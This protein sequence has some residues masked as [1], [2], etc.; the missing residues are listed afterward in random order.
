MLL[1][2]FSERVDKQLWTKNPDLGDINVF[3]NMNES[4]EA[5]RVTD[6]ILI[7]REKEYSLSDF[8][9]FYRTNAQSRALEDALRRQGLPYAIIG[10]LK[11]YDRAEI[12][13]IMAYLK[14]I[15]NPNDNISFKRVVNVPKR[16]VGKTSI[17][18]LE[19]FA[20]AKGASLFES[21]KFVNS[22]IITN[23]S[24]SALNSFKSI[25]EK[26]INLKNVKTVKEIVESVIN[27]TG[28]IKE[29]ESV[30]NPETKSKI[31]NIQELVSAVEDFERRSPDKS[32]AGY[33]S[34][35]AL[36]SDIDSWQDS[37]D[38]VTLMTL[39]LAKGLEFKN[40]FMVGL[41]EGLF[42]I[43][44]SAYDRTELEEERRLMY[45]G[46]TR[47]KE[48][49]Y[50]TW[51]SERTVFGKTK[52]NVPSRFLIEAGFKEQMSDSSAA[53]VVANR[54]NKNDYFKYKT[55]PSVQYETI[56]DET[57]YED[58]KTDNSPYQIGKMVSH[59]AFGNGKI[60]EKT[61]SG[62]DLKLIILF[63]NGQWKKLLAKFA[64]L[65]VLD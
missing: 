46:M 54:Y 18:K 30:E 21:L 64:N 22:E 61:G 24:L 63:G 36:V 20:D 38:K 6:L 44:E 43:G 16:G 40:V 39:H 5:R 41:E 9:I 10:S 49:L 59:P 31:E 17:E 47:A 14:L 19:K 23:S 33:L 15:H 45:V 55:K 1:K 2:E 51:A 37:D 52:W 62:D 42:P 7:N 13:D 65:T 25:I 56:T 26:N 12:K 58:I 4:D 27:D 53:K 28:Y 35:I 34:Q 11:F 60:I 57:I 48:N 50:M 8:A 3:Q 29:L 32:L